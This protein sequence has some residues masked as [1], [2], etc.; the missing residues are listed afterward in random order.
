MS[1]PKIALFADKGSP[2]IE[3]LR[4]IVQDEGAQPVVFDIRFGG[5]SAPS[6]TL[7]PEQLRWDGVGFADIAAVHVR[8]RALNTPPT[9]T[10][11][12]DWASYSELRCRFLREQEHQSATF[13]FFD[14]L[15][16]RGKLV[17]N[18]FTSA[19]L[20]HD[21]KAQVYQKFRAL[22]LT[23]P[24][25]LTTNDPERALSFLN[26]VGQAVAKPAIGVGST[27][28]V[29][30]ADLERLPEFRTCPVLL[31][32]LI[33]GDTLRV[34][35]VADSVVLA[36]KIISEGQVDSRTA[37]KGVEYFKLPDAEEALLVAANRALGLHYAAWDIL[38]T[39]DG[40]YFYLDCNSGPYIM[41]VGEENA[42]IVLRELARYMIAYARTRSVPEAARAVR[43]WQ[44][45]YL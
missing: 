10:P 11:L 7:A 44:P 14:Q 26:E 3:K 45:S 15:V 2:Q 33:I 39:S 12:L 9:V 43:P 41:W 37:P 40:R 4:D 5:E 30:E 23:V 25:A 34:H 20:D 21:A 32:E 19:Y 38:A 31:Q 6:V 36:L 24:R 17:I 13:S 35:I 29:L 18:P 28:R 16:R 27:R 22:G 42:A 1:S 8:C